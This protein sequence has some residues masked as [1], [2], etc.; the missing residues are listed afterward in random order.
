[1]EQTCK[2]SKKKT[3][4]NPNLINRSTCLRSLRGSLY[5]FHRRIQLHLPTNQPASQPTAQPT[6][7]STNQP[8]NQ[9]TNQPTTNTCQTTFASGAPISAYCYEMSK[10][11]RNIVVESTEPDVLEGSLNTKA[12]LKKKNE[13]KT[14]RTAEN[15]REEEYE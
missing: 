8:L 12:S 5:C 10:L 6:N 11:S 3:K 4:K 14:S 1:M 7:R 2:Q 13:C 9:P 15:R